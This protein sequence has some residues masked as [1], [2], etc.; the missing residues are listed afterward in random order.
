M[1][2]ARPSPKE[3]QHPI[4]FRGKMYEKQRMRKCWFTCRTKSPLASGI[5]GLLTV[6]LLVCGLV[7]NSWA[8]LVPGQPTRHRHHDAPV[9][10]EPSAAQVFAATIE[11]RGQLKCFM[12]SFQKVNPGGNCAA[13]GKPLRS[14]H[15]AEDPILFNGIG[16]AFLHGSHLL[17]LR[18]DLPPP[19]V[20][21][22]I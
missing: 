15:A 2:D 6:P 17:F 4:D 11:D 1:L 22:S 9:L 18:L 10:C 13:K 16:P 12:R 20:S 3:H 21:V 5:G 14:V 7:F 8:S 19:F